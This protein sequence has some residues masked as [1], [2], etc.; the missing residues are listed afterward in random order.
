[1]PR[2]I[3]SHETYIGADQNQLAPFARAFHIIDGDYRVKEAAPGDYVLDSRGGYLAV[4]GVR[5]LLKSD[6]NE[7]NA[8]SLA[9]FLVP[10]HNQ[11]P[12]VP[13]TLV[14][15]REDQLGPTMDEWVAERER[16][17]DAHIAAR[18]GRDAEQE[19]ADAAIDEHR[20]IARGLAGLGINAVSINTNK[21][22]VTLSFDEINSLITAAS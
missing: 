21:R 6:A 17:A 5:Q 2:T 7:L 10:T 9:D 13:G 3:K 1:M 8:L 18:E 12:E 15:V 14:V 11:R 22:Q 19:K 16:L 4:S 20:S